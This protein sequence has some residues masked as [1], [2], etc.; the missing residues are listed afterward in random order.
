MT[1]YEAKYKYGQFDLSE[2]ESQTKDALV[3]GMIGRG[4]C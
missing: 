2:Y 3:L 1:Y 4:E